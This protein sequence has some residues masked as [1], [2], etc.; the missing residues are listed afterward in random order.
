MDDLLRPL[1]PVSDE[2]WAEIEQ[3]A[4]RVLERTLAARKF[5]D[6]SGPHG[7]GKAAVNLGRVDPIE[8]VPEAGVAASLREVQPLT[9]LRVPFELSRGELEAVARGA[10]DPAL[11]P[12]TFAAR[13]AALAEDRSIFHGFS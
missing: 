8:E 5:V 13:K 3:E 4:R 2:A 11:E 9:E 10:D 6:F 12:V 1:S 7:L